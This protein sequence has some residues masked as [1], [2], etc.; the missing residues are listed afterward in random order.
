VRQDFLC[1]IAYCPRVP[2]VPDSKLGPG[3][4]KGRAAVGFVRAA[5]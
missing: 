1:F 2:S 3:L 4:G 5:F